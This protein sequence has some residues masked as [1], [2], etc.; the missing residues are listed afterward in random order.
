MNRTR[1]GANLSPRPAILNPLPRPRPRPCPRP[2][3]RLRPRLPLTVYF[4]PRYDLLP[5]KPKERSARG[6]CQI[7]PKLWY[8]LLRRVWN[9]SS[10]RQRNLSLDFSDD[11]PSFGST[12]A[13]TSSKSFSGDALNL[14]FEDDDMDCDEGT[15]VPA[16]MIFE[17]RGNRRAPH[18]GVTFFLLVFVPPV[19]IISNVKDLRTRTQG[20]V[21]GK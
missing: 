13:G 5:L 16:K 12:I 6:C 1:A 19:G 3:P 21:K 9:V 11:K 20:H 8:Y 4:F 15:P 2:R 14:Q 17:V 18:P 10:N 7:W